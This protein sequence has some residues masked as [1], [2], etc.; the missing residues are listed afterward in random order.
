MGKSAFDRLAQI[1]YCEPQPTHG[2]LARPP[3]QPVRGPGI[4]LDE[5][6]PK[7]MAHFLMEFPNAIRQVA[8]HAERTVNDPGHVRYGWKTVQDG[9]RRYSEALARHIL[10]TPESALVVD[11]ST[12]HPAAMAQL[13]ESATVVAWN[14][15][16]R[17]ELLLKSQSSDG[18]AAESSHEARR[19]V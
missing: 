2:A 17:L 7:V 19:V 3:D 1:N 8:T 9:F 6:K 14:A 11:D 4:K 16:A 13:V 12:I 10:E 15:M 5:G 18:V